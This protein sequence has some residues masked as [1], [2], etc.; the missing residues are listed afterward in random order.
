MNPQSPLFIDE[1]APVTWGCERE[2]VREG[3][4]LRYIR[5]F[6]HEIGTFPLEMAAILA[7]PATAHPAPALLHLH[8]GAQC[9]NVEI[10]LAWAKR[11]FVTLCPDWSVPAEMHQADHVTRW[12]EGVPPVHNA[13]LEAGM[14]TIGHVIRGVRRG[15]SLL[16]AMPE[17]RSERIGMVGI[18][19]GGL[20]TWL[21]NGTDS[22]LSAAIAVYGSGLA[23]GRSASA[24]WRS[25]FQPESVAKTQRAPILHLNGTHDFFGHLETSEAL[26]KRVGPA[27]RRLYVPNEDHGLNEQARDCAF[28]WLQLHLNGEGALPAEPDGNPGPGKRFF[29]APDA[30]RRAVWR[31]VA[32]ENLPGSGRWFV[33]ERHP[34][35]LAFSSPVREG[36]PG[37]CPPASGPR[38]RI[39]S[40]EFDGWTGLYLRWELE[41][42]SVHAPAI[43][44]LHVKDGGVGVTPRRDRLCLFV[45]TDAD[46]PDSAEG[47]AVKLSAPAGT[48]VN[49]SLFTA[50]E[51]AEAHRWNVAGKSCLASGEQTLF[52]AFSLFQPADQIQSAGEGQNTFD[53]HSLCVLRL[54]MICPASQPVDLRLRAI[55]FR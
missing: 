21:V 42:L 34:G 1:S 46:C 11:G 17:V 50:P 55:G 31:E 44:H 26:L 16:Q 43:G 15:L 19:W 23:A 20:M 29:H 47:I 35:G 51:I 28:A 13:T 54:E 27:A 40:A 3:I 53:P 49:L 33:T 30:G 36:P 10:A 52:F 4:S 24:S 45:R 41:N 12:P 8:G 48:S 22:R 7:V 39:W 37:S 25:S 14:A 18:S 5:Y 32:P 6:S 2:C 9:A 38:P